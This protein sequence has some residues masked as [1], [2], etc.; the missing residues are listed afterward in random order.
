[1]QDRIHDLRNDRVIVANDAGENA[2]IIVLPTQA[3]DQVV[4]E[5]VFHAA[6]AQTFFGKGTAAQF[7]KCARKNS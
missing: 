6:G 5:F 1:M 4:A 3:R 2:D 7:A